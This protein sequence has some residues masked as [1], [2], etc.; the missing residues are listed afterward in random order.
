MMARAFGLRVALNCAGSDSCFI[1]I[2]VN[3]QPGTRHSREN[4]NR[5]IRFYK[6]L[7]YAMPDQVGQD[8][9]ERA[10]HV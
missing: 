4:G 7:N 8:G 10:V 9:P 2:L 1:R 3:N 5:T 6:A